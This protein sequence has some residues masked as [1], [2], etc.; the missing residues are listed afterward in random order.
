MITELSRVDSTASS[1]VTMPSRICIVGSAYYLPD[2]RR[3]SSEAEALIRNS[4]HGFTPPNDVLEH[5][6]G[7]RC[8]RVA[9]EGDQTSDL[10]ARAANRVFEQTNIDPG[11]IDLLI[12]ASAGQDLAEP[13]TANIV[14][15]KIGT[16]CPAFDVKNACN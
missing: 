14:Q 4:S 11:E 6:T 8:R 10:A 7:V 12:F 15:E 16:A 5:I 3:S 9:A 13:A 2:R 1:A